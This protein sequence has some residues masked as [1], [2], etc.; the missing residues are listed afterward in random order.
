MSKFR[1]G[2]IIINLTRA[3]VCAGDGCGKTLETGT[4]ARYYPAFFNPKT[5]TG[6]KARVFCISHEK[7][8]TEHDPAPFVEQPAPHEAPK[9]APVKAKAKK[10]AVPAQKPLTLPERREYVR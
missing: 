10:P 6:V 1:K 8:E 9:P 7:P 4:K 5:K 2:G 3:G